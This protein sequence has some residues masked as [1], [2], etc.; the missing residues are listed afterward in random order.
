MLQR[1]GAD[2]NARNDWGETP[3]HAALG[4]NK[5]KTVEVL[6]GLGSELPETGAHQVPYTADGNRGF[7]CCFTSQF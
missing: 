3:L 7:R 1:L 5:V 6:I 2:V 4:N